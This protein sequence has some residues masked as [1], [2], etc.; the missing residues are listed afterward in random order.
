[1]IY[2][3]VFRN[4]EHLRMPKEKGVDGKVKEIYRCYRISF[5]L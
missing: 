1:M 5:L 2:K 3:T 4:Y